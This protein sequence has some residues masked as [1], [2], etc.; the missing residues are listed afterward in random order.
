MKYETPEM[1][2]EIISFQDVVC[3]S[4]NTPTY[5]PGGDNDDGFA[6]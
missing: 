5:Q 6:W 3:T 1:A 4:D 2:I